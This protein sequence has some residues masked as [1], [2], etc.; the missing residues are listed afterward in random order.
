[1]TYEMMKSIWSGDV[2]EDQKKKAGGR[3]FKAKDV[4]LPPLAAG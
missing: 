4:L 2:E 3:G 1:M